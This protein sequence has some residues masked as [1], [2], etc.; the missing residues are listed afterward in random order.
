M[1]KGA[2]CTPYSVLGA[3]L[4]RLSLCTDQTAPTAQCEDDAAF[5]AM[6]APLDEQ[7]V[8]DVVVSTIFRVEGEGGKKSLSPLGNASIFPDEGEMK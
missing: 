3:C 6:P 7:S 5:Q 4:T 1:A 8:D 2:T